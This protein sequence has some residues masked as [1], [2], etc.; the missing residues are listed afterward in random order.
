MKR[1]IGICYAVKHIKNQSKHENLIATKHDRPE[2]NIHTKSSKWL[3]KGYFHTRSRE[4]K[5]R[6]RYKSH[7]RHIIKL[8]NRIS[9]L[10]DTF[11]KHI[12]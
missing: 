9:L 4:Y 11:S 10:F 6:L 2:L 7:H 12:F 5:L 8:I 1:V 3:Q